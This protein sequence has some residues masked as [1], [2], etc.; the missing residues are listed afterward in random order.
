VTS[1]D[2]HGDISKLDDDAK[3][4]IDVVAKAYSKFNGQQLSDLTHSEEPWRRARAGIPDN[5][6]SES[7]ITLY[8]PARIMTYAF[9]HSRLAMEVMRPVSAVRAFQALQQASRMSS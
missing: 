1:D 4:T 9:A 2:I 5:V 8:Q 3:E 6:R 7:E